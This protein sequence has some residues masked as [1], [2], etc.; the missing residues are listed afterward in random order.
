MGGD[1]LEKTT[2]CC[3]ISEEG[4]TCADNSEAVQNNANSLA[5]RRISKRPILMR[6]ILRDRVVVAKSPYH[7]LTPKKANRRRK[8]VITPV[9]INNPAA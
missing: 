5:T 4:A 9:Y 6:K 3:G 8:V 1:N 7:S 2:C